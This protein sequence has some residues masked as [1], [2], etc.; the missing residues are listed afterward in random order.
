MFSKKIAVIFGIGLCAMS[1]SFAA[2][3]KE[4]KFPTKTITIVNPYSAGGGADM[5]ARQLAKELE[6]ILGVNVIVV[7]KVGGSGAIGTNEVSKAKPDGYTLLIN[8]KALV[9][10]YYLGVSQISVNDLDPVCRL[11]A[12][13]QALTVNKDS[14]YSTLD[15]FLAAAKSEPGK[16]TVGV[17]GIGGMSHLLAENIKIA[18]GINLKVVGF[19]GGAPSRTALMGGH[20]SSI[21]A[22]LG[23]VKSL[24]DAGNLKLLAIADKKRNSVF[25]DVPTFTEKGIDVELNQWRAIW[26]PKGT[27]KTATEILAAAFK[28]A[29][30]SEGF[31]KL[32][33]DT[34][35]QNLFAGPDELKSE[36]SKQDA[37]L[38]KLVTDSGLLKKN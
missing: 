7:N 31:K 37:Y 22:Q 26:A 28:K 34:V 10:S 29:M 15:E 12:A 8:D 14:P 1:V 23:E 9:S 20:V 36:L 3:Q 5:V 35:T 2:S 21:T 17:S 16:L 4:P 33:K 25:P 18:S 32:M 13:S 30:D 27:P 11:D 19:D 38:K 24:V 6:P